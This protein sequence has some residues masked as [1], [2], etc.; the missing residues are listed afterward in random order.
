MQHE[1]VTTVTIAASRTILALVVMKSLHALDASLGPLVLVLESCDLV[2]HCVQLFQLVLEA[3][4]LC[5]KLGPLGAFTH[6]C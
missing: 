2:A 4:L 1:E 5:Q 3:L 6:H